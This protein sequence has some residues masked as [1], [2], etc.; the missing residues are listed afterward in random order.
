MPSTTPVQKAARRLRSIPSD[1]PR[2][3]KM[4]RPKAKNPM[5]PL[6]LCVP[7]KI[8]EWLQSQAEADRRTVSAYVNI[9]LED[10]YKQ[11]HPEE[12]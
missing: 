10:I 5:V 6:S 3:K 12:S 7:P 11:S 1:E 4:G 8:K 2:E 9:L